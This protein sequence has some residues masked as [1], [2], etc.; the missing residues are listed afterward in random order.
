MEVQSMRHHRGERGKLLTSFCE[1][2][3]LLN[4]KARDNKWDMG[5]YLSG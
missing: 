4:V 1:Y 2:N 3:K 5:L